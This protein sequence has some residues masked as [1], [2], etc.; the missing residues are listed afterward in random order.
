MAM[1]IHTTTMA[2]RGQMCRR[3]D[4]VR[5]KMLMEREELGC[6]GGVE[7]SL[8]ATPSAVEK[9]G[10]DGAVACAFLRLGKWWRRLALGS[11][12]WRRRLVV[13]AGSGEDEN[14]RRGW[15]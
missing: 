10:F 5:R 11:G 7:R 13:A 14:E 3:G 12:E 9:A 4:R 1:E 8:E 2:R 15:S 6:G